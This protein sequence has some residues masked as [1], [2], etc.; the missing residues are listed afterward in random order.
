MPNKPDKSKTKEELIKEND[1]LQ[2]RLDEA[3]ET[4]SAIQNGEIDAIVTP[5][6][7]DGP[8]VYTLESADY[9]YRNL[10]QEMNE[11]VATLTYD[12]TIFYS[13]AQLAA[14]LQIPLEKFTGQKLNSFILPK[15]L[16]TYHA[17]FEKGFETRSSGEISIQ[18]VDGT[19]IPVHVSINSLKDLKGVYI[20]ITDLS[21]QKHH[22]E[23]K[24]VYNRL[25]KSL[26]AMQESE[27]RYKNILNNLQDAYMQTDNEGN[28]IIASPSAAIM[29]NYETP[30]EM[31]GIPSIN[32]YKNPKDKDYVLDEL[33]KYGKLENNE[34]EAVR[35]DGTCFF[36][37]Q[38]A[39]FRYDDQGRKI[40]T[41]TLVRDI[42]ERK[43][44]DEALE[45]SKI[46]FQV[47]IQ[48]LNT[49]VALVD[50]KGNFNVVNPAF[51]RMFGL[52]TDI[53]ILNVNS[54]DWSRWKVYDE[55]GNLLDVDEHPVRKV[56]ITGKRVENQLI[57]VRN[58]G[59]NRL[60]W[61]LISAEPI[62]NNRGTINKIICTY[63]DF[64]KRKMDEQRKQE[65][66]DKEKHLT[67]ELKISNIEL[68]EVQDELTDTIKQLE[69]SNSEL[70]HF[71]Y[72][73]SHDLREP[74]RMITSFLQL[75]E[76][77]YKDKLDQDA[78]EFIGFA[79][80][81]AKRLDHMINDLLQYSKITSQNREITP[82]NLENVLEEVLTN[83]KVPIE[84]NNAVITH[85]PLPLIKGDEQLKVRLFQNLIGNAI[86]YRSEENPKIHI[87]AAKEKN[88][89]LISIKDNGI[90]MSPDYLDQI[91]TI[92]KRLHT[93]EEYEGT[94]IG[95][96]IAQKIVHQQGGQI[97]AESELKKGTTFYFTL[98]NAQ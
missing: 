13:N 17:I 87:S 42:T 65:L 81:G 16:E 53:D 55:N 4:L 28:I 41:E 50:D 78:N 2:S 18:S 51:M 32:L 30:E 84:E 35:E 85:D 31:I 95:L 76:R 56:A 60:I 68:M 33:D 88:H 62:F 66:L 64:T 21:E 45:R 8:Q 77:R 79:V 7:V 29:Y 36:A 43:I 57:H 15:D 22:E 1:E 27:K 11:G 5:Q 23:L 98:Y 38:N 73:A 80:D 69:L 71:A 40:G 97:W 75:L 25:N 58:P 74:L 83:L 90:G 26:D 86:K 49:G 94:G 48:N 19:I 12:G 34:I 24:I 47:L 59:D 54:Q 63:Y 96:S 14:M 92:F 39:Q 52:D 89:Y 72:I 82:V 61:M 6:G 93:H 46:E 3:E 67:E 44:A 10:V 37:S 20:V 91:F 70:E 9:L